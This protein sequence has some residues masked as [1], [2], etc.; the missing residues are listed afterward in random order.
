MV[1]P[2]HSARH[3]ESHLRIVSCR[4]ATFAVAGLL[5][6]AGG[7]ASHPVSKPPSSTS[8]ANEASSVVV[9][10]RTLTAGPR[11]YEIV[12]GGAGRER[13]GVAISSDG[14]YVAF[15][16][17]DPTLTPGT[18]NDT[19]SVF[20]RDRQAGTVERISGWHVLERGTGVEGDR[21]CAQDPVMTPDGRFVAYI[22]GTPD[23]GDDDPDYNLQR[24]FLRDRVSGTTRNVS[25]GIT[26]P[27]GKDCMFWGVTVSADG[28]FVAFTCTRTDIRYYVRDMLRGTTRELTAP[29]EKGRVNEIDQVLLGGRY[30]VFNSYKRGHDLD[31]ASKAGDFFGTYLLETR[32]GSRHLLTSTVDGGPV[33]DKE[34]YPEAGAASLSA[35]GRYVAFSSAASNL[36]AGD[37]NGAE[38]CFRLDLLTKTTTRVSLTASSEQATSA[39]DPRYS[40]VGFFSPVLS[41]D[42]SRA[43]FGASVLCNL[44]PGLAY[45]PGATG[46]D[47]YLRDLDASTT[48]RVTDFGPRYDS[49]ATTSESNSGPAIGDYELSGDGNHAVFESNLA[50]VPFDD[51][52]SFDA[53]VRDLPR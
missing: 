50:V 6:L 34:G 36:V 11:R 30:I 26:A 39:A 32:D 47:V 5:L 48:V 53:L 42:G 40:D 46:Y 4:V 16:S 44:V 28:R 13:T 14:R 8:G 38:D 41:A 9:T 3:S 49:L 25:A 24:V 27:Q 51:A 33:I 19:L 10:G 45:P 17:E 18:P 29:R 37:T 23:P 1:C 22:S 12:S 35:D 2:T 20:M 15:A 21:W 43:L 7:C 52:P 31:S